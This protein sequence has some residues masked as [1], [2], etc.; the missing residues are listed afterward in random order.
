VDADIEQE[1]AWINEPDPSAWMI[2][3]E[4]LRCDR[5]DAV[6]HK[7]SAS[8]VLDGLHRAG[9]KLVE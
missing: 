3:S 2:I 5:T 1:L 8:H 4:V 6:D 7:T 9:I